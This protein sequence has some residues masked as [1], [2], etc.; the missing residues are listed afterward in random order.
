MSIYQSRFSNDEKKLQNFEN[1]IEQLEDEESTIL[2]ADNPDVE[3]ILDAGSGSNREVNNK[4]LLNKNLNKQESKLSNDQNLNW[5]VSKY[6][7]INMCYKENYFDSKQKQEVNNQE[8]S[9]TTIISFPLD[10]HFKIIKKSD[11]NKYT[12][13]D[14]IYYKNREIKMTNSIVFYLNHYYKKTEYFR[15]KRLVVNERPITVNLF[16]IFLINLLVRNS[17]LSMSFL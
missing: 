6:I 4:I 15:F 7:D 13:K 1:V 10:K 11:K 16:L 5:N 17:K 8:T 9:K 12:I 2:Y 14:I 3:D